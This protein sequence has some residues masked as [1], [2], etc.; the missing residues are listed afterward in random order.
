MNPDA[1]PFAVRALLADHA[2]CVTVTTRR[3]KQRSGGTGTVVVMVA[4]LDPRVGVRV[5]ALAPTAR[6]GLLMVLASAR[7]RA[8]MVQSRCCKYAKQLRSPSRVSEA[9]RIADDV[10]AVVA[11][12]AEMQREVLRLWPEPV[13]LDSSAREKNSDAD[14]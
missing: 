6:E 13:A 10:A 11:R 3:V 4:E 9:M 1:V 2:G 8:A 5:R 14:T 12:L 7:D